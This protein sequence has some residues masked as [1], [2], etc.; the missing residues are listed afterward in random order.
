MP[1]PDQ[2]SEAWTRRRWIKH[3]M[4]GTAMA[5]GP[6]QTWR[7]TLLADIA[8]GT[9]PTDIISLDLSTLPGLLDGSTPSIQLVLNGFNQQ[10]IMIN[11]PPFNGQFFVLDSRCTHEGCI[12]PPWNPTQNILCGCHGSNYLYD[13]SLISGAAGPMQPPLATYNFNWDGANL[14]QIQVPGLDL[15]I[16]SITVQA[17]SPTNKRL[18]L[19]FPA[20]MGGAYQVTTST[21]L[22]K[23]SA[24]VNF[25]TTAT[26]T[27]DNSSMIAQFTG[28]QDIWV[29]NSNPTI[30]A[31]Y[32]VELILTNPNGGC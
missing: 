31:F 32:R 13:G 26:G 5:L 4:L 24:P 30:N 23:W 29:D 15:T 9:P 12:V 10:I 8:P 16:N 3:F 25:A 7:G 6:G 19:S 21:D 2:K 14:L 17:S 20:Q 22:A 28:N 1:L 18:H 27:A 11:R